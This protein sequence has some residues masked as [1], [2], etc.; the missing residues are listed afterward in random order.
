MASE[1]FRRQLRDESEQ[2]W[3]E[4]LIDAALYEKLA[5][6]YQFDRLEKEASHRF[7]AILIGL[8]AVLLGLGAITFVAANWQVWPRAFKML[9][10]FSSFVGVNAAGFYFWRKPS[11]QG[12]QP[13]LGQGLLLLGA[14]LLG[15]NLG[16]M[17]QMFHQSGDWYGLLLVWG[18]AVAA[19]AYSLRLMPLG[20]LALILV[21]LGYA[22][23]WF[24]RSVWQEFSGTAL[25]IQHLPLVVSLVFVPLAYWCRSRVIFGL[26]A[27]AIA[28][29]LT[30]N[31]NPSDA[32]SV[33]W[34]LAIAFVLP[35][36][37]LWGYSTDLWRFPAGIRLRASA[38]PLP[39]GG[40]TPADPFQ[41][42]SRRL[43]VWFLS[44]LFFIFAFRGWWITSPTEDVARLKDWNW[45]PLIDA[46]ILGIVAV[47]SWMQLKS[48]LR[49]GQ[50]Q[51][52]R[53]NSG[54]IVAFLLATA[55]L[56]IAHTPLIRVSVILVFAF[57]A[58]LFLLALGLIRDGLALAQR[59]T[60]WEGMVL[61]ILGIISRTLEYD[62]GLLLKAIV[63]AIC[64]VGV[65]VA[66][67]RFERK[68][69]PPRSSSLPHS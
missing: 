3:S 24:S 10:L 32:W 17:S 36:A 49:W 41:S 58:M 33:G 68:T 4:G 51:E 13:R 59:L 65:M 23:S 56:F 25:V 11:A 69:H 66:G 62:T 37:L 22:A 39:S 21:S 67:L 19:M 26:S 6:R 52:R 50:I 42:I 14:L 63:F 18:L 28:G 1:K 54:T 27:I 29:S 44:I 7:V 55:L 47:L 64:G 46:L 2:W 15:A 48:Q 16:L 35:P 57:N 45:F 40:T 12:G 20:V 31:L 9:L 30:F 38:R 60:F 61:L 43:A 5:D 53:I 34:I 8:G